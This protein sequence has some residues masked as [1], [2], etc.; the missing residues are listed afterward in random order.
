MKLMSQTRHAGPPLLLLA[1][2]HLLLFTASLL[3]GTFLRHGAVYVN[4]Y[5]SSKAVQDFF[6]N[7][8][9]LI[10]VSTFFFFGSAVPLGTFRPRCG[11]V[12]SPSCPCVVF[13]ELP[14]WRRCICSGIRA[15]CGR[16]I[17][18]QL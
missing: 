16:R 18:Y 1:M 17:G 5:S 13:P 10:R 11:F 7:S 12:F 8:S 15:A 4:P 9:H 2:V 3:A 14:L 6:A